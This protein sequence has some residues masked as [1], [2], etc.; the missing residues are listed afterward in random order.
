MAQYISKDALVAEIKKEIKGIYASREYVGI[1]SWE[2]HEIDG[3]ERAIEILNTLEVKEV[4]LKEE[5]YDFLDTLIGKDNGHLSEDEL[6][7]IAEYFFE[8][9][10]KQKEE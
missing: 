1:P 3:L 10:L 9:G 5:F 8:L 2:E 4:D 7:R 6:F